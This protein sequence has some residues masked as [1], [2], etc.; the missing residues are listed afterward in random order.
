[1]INNVIFLLLGPKYLFIRSFSSFHD[2][3]VVA[4]LDEVVVFD[5]LLLVGNLLK[6]QDFVILLCTEYNAHKSMAIDIN[7][8]AVW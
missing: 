3:V 8:N 5:W 6:M 4:E 2:A 7:L 1:M